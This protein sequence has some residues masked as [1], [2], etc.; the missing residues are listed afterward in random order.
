MKEYSSNLS[1]SA[2]KLVTSLKHQIS[3]KLDE[4]IQNIQ[5]SNPLFEKIL[6]QKS[7]EQIRLKNLEA[8]LSSIGE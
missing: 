4:Y 8:E 6:A 3:L 2:L 5:K 7:E 1:N